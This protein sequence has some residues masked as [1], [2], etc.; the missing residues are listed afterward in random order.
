[1]R[2]KLSARLAACQQID[3]LLNSPDAIVAAVHRNPQV[4]ETLRAILTPRHPSQ[5][6]EA[7]CEGV[8]LFLILWIMR[9]R[10]RTR[11]GVLTG[12]FFICYAILRIFVEN[13]REPDASLILG[14]TRGQFFSIFL[15]VIGAGFLLA[16]AMGWTRKRAT[17]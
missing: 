2:L 16:A 7:L 10:F 6:Y 8:L 4:K 5:I 3:P 11:N 14:I 9:T 12:L 1:M 17:C 15:I 13:F